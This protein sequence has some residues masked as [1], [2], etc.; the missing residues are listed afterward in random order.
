MLARAHLQHTIV[1]YDC[2]SWRM[3]CC[4]YGAAPAYDSHANVAIRP[5]DVSDLIVYMTMNNQIRQSYLV[6][7]ACERLFSS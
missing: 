2:S 3:Q 4:L 1:A 5:E 6:D 7:T